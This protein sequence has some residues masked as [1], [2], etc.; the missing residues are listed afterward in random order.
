MMKK[1][2]AA[3][4]VLAIGGCSLIGEDGSPDAGSGTDDYRT[5]PCACEEVEMRLRKQF[6]G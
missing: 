5:S 4:F 6:V 2:F 1:L 3:L